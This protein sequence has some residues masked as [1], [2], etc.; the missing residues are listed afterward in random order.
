ML[1]SMDDVSSMTLPIS[2]GSSVKV[3]WSTVDIFVAGG[4]VGCTSGGFDVAFNALGLGL[5]DAPEA[6][7][8]P[9]SLVDVDGFDL[10]RVDADV[11]AVA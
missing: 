1:D 10:C 5:D 11:L 2:Y 9:G 4:D 7:L 6:V 8:D 3:D